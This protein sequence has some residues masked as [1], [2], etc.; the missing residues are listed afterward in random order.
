MKKDLTMEELVNY[1]KQY[2]FVFQGSEIYGGLANSWDFGPL[3][4]L[5]KENIRQAW[6]KS[7][8][9]ENK[10]NYGL[11]SAIIMNPKVWEASGHVT[12]FADPLIDCK[13]CKARFRADKLIEDFTGGDITADGWSNEEIEKYI[14][15]HDIYC[16]KCNK[17]DFTPIRKF[18][19]L[20]ETSLG[21]TD[22]TKNTVYLR[23][24]TAQGIFVYFLNV[25]RSMSFK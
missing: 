8:I 16:P 23:G 5:L 1:C 9:E 19:L 10:Y 17:K 18:N 20:F 15:E 7:F 22:D 11:D 25:Q 12:S 2:G 21:V 13:K 6:K 3:G 4:T 14:E 24:E